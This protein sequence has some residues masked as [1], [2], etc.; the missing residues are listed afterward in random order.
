MALLLDDHALKIVMLCALPL[1]AAV[2]FL[3]KDFGS[4][5]RRCLKGKKIRSG[6]S[7]F[8]PPSGSALAAITA[9]SA[10][11]PYFHDY[12]VYRP[13]GAWT[14]DRFPAVRRSGTL[15]LQHRLGGGLADERARSCWNS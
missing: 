10:P 7:S 3:K 6:I 1:V 5:D 15:T 12:G 2:L 13:D 4:G 9:W 14:A 11:E 8:Q